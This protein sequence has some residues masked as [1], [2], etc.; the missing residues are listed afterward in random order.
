LGSPSTTRLAPTFR[1]LWCGLQQSP[2]CFAFVLADGRGNSI[3]IEVMSST[4]ALSE[5]VEILD[6]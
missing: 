4:D 6:D 5:L 3:D 2:T 1:T